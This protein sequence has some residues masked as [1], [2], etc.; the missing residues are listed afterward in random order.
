[1]INNLLILGVE[2]LLG[3][4]LCG[5]GSG[6]NI[7]FFSFSWSIKTDGQAFCSLLDMYMYRSETSLH[8]GD[9]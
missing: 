3:Y 5:C 7:S 2:F 1:M 4:R 8:R 6:A 9:G